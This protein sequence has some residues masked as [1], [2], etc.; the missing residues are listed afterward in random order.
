MK[1]YFKWDV[2]SLEYMWRSELDLPCVF[3]TTNLSEEEV[4]KI[5]KWYNVKIEKW[6]LVIEDLHW[7]EEL[8]IEMELKRKVEETKNLLIEKQALELLWEDT[9]EVEAKIQEVVW[10]FEAKKLEIVKEETTTK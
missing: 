3:F 8:E 9:K 4:E 10:D 7:V 6:N 5:E 2:E 1:H